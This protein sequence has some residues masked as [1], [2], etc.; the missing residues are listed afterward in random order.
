MTSRSHKIP[1]EFQN[2]CPVADSCTHL[3]SGTLP[4]LLRKTSHRDR[5]G[6]SKAYW[7][8]Q[9]KV[10]APQ[11]ALSADLDAY[12]NAESLRFS[13]DREKNKILT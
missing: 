6:I 1:A 7:G 10:G 2:V 3:C 12:T 5:V 9:I 4:G 13:F 11:P 8:P